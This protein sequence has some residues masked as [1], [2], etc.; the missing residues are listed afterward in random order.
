MVYIKF[1]ECD[2]NF[3]DNLGRIRTEKNMTQKKL[4]KATGFSINTIQNYESGIS[5][6]NAKKLYILCKVL[7]VSADYLLGLNRTCS[8]ETKNT[9]DGNDTESSINSD[10]NSLSDS[11]KKMVLDLIQVL[12]ENESH[13]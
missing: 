2:F 4:A 6:P 5:I 11:S 8:N 3:K 13:K 9:T 1:N 7:E 12:K 10:Y